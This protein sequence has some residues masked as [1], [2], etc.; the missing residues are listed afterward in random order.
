MGSAL[1]AN[2][3]EVDPYSPVERHNLTVD[4]CDK[5]GL[6]SLANPLDPKLLFGGIYAY[7][8]SASSTFA[9]HCGSL[10]MELASAGFLNSST[11]IL[12]IAA[13]DGVLAKQLYMRGFSNYVAVEPSANNA[14][15]LSSAGFCVY[16]DFFCDSFVTDRELDESFSLVLGQN[17]LGH[18]PDIRDFLK[19]IYRA[20]AD[21]GVAILEI[22]S[23]EVVAETGQFEQIYHEHFHYITRGFIE[24]AASE[25]GFSRVAVD[26]YEIHGGS[27]RIFLFKSGIRAPVS[28]LD[29]SASS[30]LKKLQQTSGDR[31]DRVRTSVEKITKCG[32]RLCGIGAAAKLFAWEIMLPDLIADLE[33]IYDSAPA[34]WFKYIPGSGVQ[35]EPFK[36]IGKSASEVGV[37]FPFNIDA[38]LRGLAKD[39]GFRGGF[40]STFDDQG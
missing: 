6:I 10:V 11:S 29:E 28:P 2:K 4:A 1:V 20:L 23:F 33:A 16:K 12:E 15:L 38:E 35:V 5:C 40:L 34:K 13:N 7:Q 25:V 31:V 9:Q 8:S 21:N 36:S 22:P 39:F 14:E 27:F 17:V 19:G 37:I 24:Y 30:F 3:F 18:I 26:F 32:G